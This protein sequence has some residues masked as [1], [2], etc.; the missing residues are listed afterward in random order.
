[1]TTCRDVVGE[2]FA[3]LGVV[4]LGGNPTADELDAGLRAIEGIVL[5]LH[6]ARGPMIDVDV[7]EDLIATENQRLR[8]QAGSTVEVT[9]PNSIVI[10]VGVGCGF[11]TPPSIV[12]AVGSLSP[13]DGENSRPPRDGTR[14]EIV[15][16]T[17]ALY[18]YRADTNAW[19][20]ASPLSIDGPLPLNERYD[21][22]LAA[23]VAERLSNV[24]GVAPTPAMIK[25]IARGNAALML[26]PAT[27]R[28]CSRSIYF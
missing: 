23:L 4:A 10:S 24:V 27:V 21:G 17:Q 26:Q 15:G 12:T 18:F 9:L 5:D 2:A 3:I 1:M 8:I 6:N 28:G 7:V 22:A 11:L 19:I 13:A 20:L 16:T 25:R 14:V